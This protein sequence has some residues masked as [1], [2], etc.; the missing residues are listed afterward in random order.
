MRLQRG[1]RHGGRGYT[2]PPPVGQKRR[3]I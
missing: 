3:R 2:Q 1:R